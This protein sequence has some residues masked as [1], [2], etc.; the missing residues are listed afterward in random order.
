[1]LLSAIALASVAQQP[2]ISHLEINNVRPTILGD[3]SCFVPQQWNNQNHLPYTPCLTWEVP[4]GSGKGTIY[5]HC[6]WFGGLDSGEELHL[7]GMRFNQNGQDYAMGPLKTADAS[8]DFMTMAKYHRIWSLTRAEIDQFVTSH[9]NAGY[10]IPEDILT[11]PAHGEE[12]YASNLAPFVDVNGDG[13]YSPA[14]GDYP[15]IKGDQ[16]LYFIFND[17]RTHTET[18]GAAIGLEVHAMVYGFDAPDDEPLKNTVFI[19][20]KFINRSANDYHNTYLGLFTDWDL[21]YSRDDFVGCDVQRNS[22]YVYNGNYSDGYDEP[23]SYDSIV[24]AQVLTV[25]N[26]PDNLG[27]TGFMYYNNSNSHMGDPQNAAEHYLYMQNCWRDGNHL[28]YGGTGYPG[29]SG[30]VGPECNY[31]FP[32]E[33][34]PAHHD[35]NWTEE[36]TGNQP[37]DRRGLAS[38]GPFDF[39]AGG[40]KELDYAM[41]TVWGRENEY[42]PMASFSRIGEFVDHIKELFT[43][44]FA[45]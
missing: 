12:G 26:G 42:G 8:T 33:T 10:Q 5:Q 16:C 43:N 40:V 15:D 35:F 38:V 9:A 21:G 1:M 14:D 25:L 32:G 23:W 2:P 3:G 44:G 18:S 37:D 28:F 31:M 4:V 7:A 27:M 6:L 13:H 17:A 19:N 20:Y 45:K 22:C 24:P 36:T 34:D 39:P 41:V 30:T 29:Q 11:W